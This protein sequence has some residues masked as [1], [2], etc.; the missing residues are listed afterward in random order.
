VKEGDKVVGI[1]TERD[2]LR[3]VILKGRASKETAV[4]TIM[5]TGLHTVAPSDTVSTAL[6]IM[7]DK[8]CR[9]LP[10][11]DSDQLVGIVSTG[12]LIKEIMSRQKFMI[13]LLKDY[14]SSR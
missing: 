5:S 11:F 2:Y 8:R 1:I 14:M 10:V 9:H 3:K 6:S 13:Q 4:A 12:D 7:T